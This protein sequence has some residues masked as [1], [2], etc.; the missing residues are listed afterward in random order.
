MI[1]QPNTPELPS[2]YHIENLSTLLDSVA[3][4]YA[5]L[6]NESEQHLLQGFRQL[7]QPG[8][9]LYYRLLTRRGTLLRIDK[10][11][12]ADVPD[13]G[14]TLAE[15]SDAGMVTVNNPAN[16]TDLL[17]LLTRPEL[18]KLF[19]L[20]GHSKLNKGEL[21]ER[22]EQQY[23][24]HIQPLIQQHHPYVKPLLQQAFDTYKI[25][26]FG[27]SHQDLTEFVINDLGHVR[28]EPYPL[29]KNTRYFQTR[30]QI[31]RQIQYSNAR[32][33]LDNPTLLQDQ[34]ALLE[35]AYS[36]PTPDEHPHLN[37]RYQKVM[38]VIARQLERLEALPEA[39]SLYQ[40]CDRPP[41]RERQARILKK[42]G[43][44]DASATLCQQIQ[45]HGQHPEELEF[46]ERFLV[47]LKTP[48]KKPPRKQA[49][50]TAWQE[51][52]ILLTNT[53]EPVELIAAQALSDARHNT[54]YV[55]NTLFN[56]LFGLLFW[57][58]LFAAIPGAF[59]N[60]FQRGPLDLNSDDF[61]PNRRSAIDRRLACLQQD[62]WQTIV[63]HHFQHK[64]GIA[65]SLVHWE[66]ITL[67]LL[68]QA[69]LCIPASH[70]HSIFFRMLQHPGLFRNGFP[71]L[72]Q[73]SETSYELIEIKGP[74]DKLQAN[75][76]RWLKYFRQE[77][78][79]ARV[80]W[81]DWHK[82]TPV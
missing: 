60:P 64:N 37:R 47:A 54:Y 7:S 32:Q 25:C 55:E 77:G 39:L 56:A 22:I 24:D 46:A 18:I 12:Y 65:N 45:Q 34:S 41:S 5:D 52:K 49:T 23:A 40:H 11:N 76:I 57:D 59:I 16:G 48:A 78:I 13:L 14:A 74:G 81:V 4:Q 27:N 29:C 21:I 70:L 42:L 66:G 68:E 17:N 9:S 43:E 73:F 15:L 35:L 58:I 69:M 30:Q 6:L 79:P 61:Y 63:L 26:F 33:Q 80:I 19:P 38:L 67:P 62:Q 1:N 36:L 50:D 3:D 71:D 51:E 82:D 20:E 8:K 72:I 44:T 75:Q 10:L 2:G 31:E 53:G 28:F